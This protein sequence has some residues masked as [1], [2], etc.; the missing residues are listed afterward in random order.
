M[1]G[2]GIGMLNVRDA[3][4]PLLQD[5][6]VLCREPIAEGGYLRDIRTRLCYCEV[7]CYA[8]QSGSVGMFIERQARAS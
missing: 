4:Q 3:R 1:Y 8:L 7:A 5:F 2:Q 6:C